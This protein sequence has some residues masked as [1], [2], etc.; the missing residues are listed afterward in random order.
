VRTSG[1]RMSLLRPD[2]MAHESGC[3]ERLRL[4][5]TACA[6]KPSFEL[7]PCLMES[8]MK[9]VATSTAHSRP[10]PWNKGKLIGQADTA[11]QACMGDPQY[12]HL[13]GASAISPFSISASTANCVAAISSVCASP[14]SRRMATPSSYERQTKTG[15]CLRP[16]ARVDDLTARMSSEARRMTKRGRSLHRDD[17]CRPGRRGPAHADH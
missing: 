7:F 10:Q 5:S 4:P 14:M 11:A 16:I 9:D 17:E 15:R 1:Q 6:S 3:G 8:A 13:S 12:L 2:D